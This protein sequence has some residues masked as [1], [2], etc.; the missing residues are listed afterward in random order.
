MR[1]STYLF[2]CPR[3][4]ISVQID[5]SSEISSCL[6]SLTNFGIQRA[7][8]QVAMG[9]EWAHAECL[10]QG[11]GLTVVGL[12]YGS[13]WWIAPRRNVTQ[14][15]QGIRLGAP[16]LALMGEGLRLLHTLRRATSLL[17]MS[18]LT[19]LLLAE[20]G[21]LFG[22]LTTTLQVRLAAG[23]ERTLAA[24]AC[25]PGFGVDSTARHE[26]RTSLTLPMLHFSEHSC[27][28]PADTL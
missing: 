12:G 3:W 24:V 19:P 22:H 14:E 1:C 9:L 4:S 10:G 26:D 17:L 18:Q 21:Q 8:A 28:F 11:E 23:A 27:P 25:T 7:E 16:Q 13:V 6:L 2:K 15:A 5:G 20:S